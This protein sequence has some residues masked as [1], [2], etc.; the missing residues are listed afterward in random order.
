M[1][2]EKTELLMPT[3]E[4]S[5]AVRTLGNMHV[6]L[7]TILNSV[8]D[9]IYIKDSQSRFIKINAAAAQRLGLPS[10]D[11]ALG[12]T[13]FDFMPPEKAGEFQRDEQRIMQ[14][15]EPLI[16]KAEKQILPDGQVGWTSTTKVPLRDAAG[17]IVGLMGINRDITNLVRAEEALRQTRDELEVRVSSRTQDL[18]QANLALEK[19]IQRRDEVQKALTR[20]H[21]TLRMLVDNL[22]DIIFLKDAESRFLLVNAACAVQLGISQPEEAVGKTDADFVTAELARRYR[23]DEVAIMQSGNS[24]HQ[25]EPTLHKSTGKIGCSL[26]TKLSVKDGEGKVIG[27]LGIARDITPLKDAEK[28]LEAVHKD[29]VEAARAAG[30]AEVAIGVLHN[31]GNVLNSVNVSAGFLRHHFSNSKLASLPKIIQLFREHLGDI[32]HFLTEDERGRQVVPYMEKLAAILQGEQEVLQRE[33]QNLD[34][35]VKHIAEIVAAQQNHARVCGVVETINLAELVEDALKLH[36][37]SYAKHGVSLVREFDPV[38]AISVDKHK[39]LQILVNLFNNAKQACEA[40]SQNDKQVT[41]R[42][43]AVGETRIKI[44]VA[45]NGIGISPDNLTRLFSQGFTTR[46]DGHGFGLHSGALDARE[47]GGALRVQSDGLG[48]GATFTLELPTTPPE[49][50]DPKP[51]SD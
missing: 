21:H 25:E 28:K 11:L 4:F 17:K 19:E 31:V 50:F 33:V 38:P 45:D 47:L 27:L 42:I 41:I 9:R 20:S 22:P 37:A 44:Q 24:V 51:E 7:E 14:T 49:R 30:M 16:N 13:D 10:P 26:T 46:K 39:V 2:L 15:G 6:S 3:S 8:P 43:N 35:K 1:S 36:G 48:K 12:K 5:D 29:L 34:D 32:Q 23:A 18:A 40:S